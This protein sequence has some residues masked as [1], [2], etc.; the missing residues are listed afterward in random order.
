ML[1]FPA[2]PSYTGAASGP[3]CGRPLRVPETSEFPLT[4]VRKRLGL[5]QAKPSEGY[6][7]ADRDYC[8]PAHRQGLRLHQ[9]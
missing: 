5:S 3:V 1:D 8:S 9:G 6:G 7:H 4:A 2:M